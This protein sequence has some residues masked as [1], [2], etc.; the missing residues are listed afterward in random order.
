MNDK[1]K[2][3][4]WHACQHRDCEFKVKILATPGEKIRLSWV[5]RLAFLHGSRAKTG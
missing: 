1:V 3:M 2:T 5:N 4:K